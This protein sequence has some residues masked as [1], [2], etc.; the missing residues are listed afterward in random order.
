MIAVVTRRSPLRR[1][2]AGGRT[3]RCNEALPALDHRLR[4]LKVLLLWKRA[5]KRMGWAMEDVDGSS[6]FG[7]RSEVNELY[8]RVYTRHKYLCDHICSCLLLHALFVLH[9]LWGQPS[10]L[11]PAT[12]QVPG[13]QDRCYGTQGVPMRV[14]AR[15]DPLHCALPR[16][17]VRTPTGGTRAC[18]HKA[19]AIWFELSVCRL[20]V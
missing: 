17:S 9:D 5:N 20:S 10:L 14:D 16:C 11:P 1:R 12:A 13:E 18:A 8:A 15:P 19:G 3:T 6:N 4:V 7:D 2:R